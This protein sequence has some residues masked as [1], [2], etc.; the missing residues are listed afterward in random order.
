MAGNPSHRKP[1]DSRWELVEVSDSYGRLCVL[2]R[3]R[4]GAVFGSGVVKQ[5]D[6]CGKRGRAYFL[7]SCGRAYKTEYRNLRRK[8]APVSC[9]RCSWERIGKQRR[10]IDNPIPFGPLRSL[11]SHRYT[12]MVSR[13]YDPNHK[14]Y[15]NYGGRGVRIC[16]EW[17]GDRN[18]FFCYVMSLPD[19]D[20]LGLDM[21]R[22]DNEGH[23]E[24]GNIRLCSR[25]ANTEN[26]RNTLVV[27]YGGIPYTYRAFREKYCP[28]WSPNAAFWHLE[29]GKTPEWIVDF[30]W[31]TRGSVR[32]PELRAT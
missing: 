24:P 22:I 21:D 20:K 19:W 30:Y 9:P 2:A 12:G 11:W 5:V 27:Q 13:C 3:P 4:I 32:H 31:E 14:A 10:K 7:C 18:K 8:N 26:R 25:R 16:Q 28:T 1:L 6:P 23:Y 29:R 15:P 17:V